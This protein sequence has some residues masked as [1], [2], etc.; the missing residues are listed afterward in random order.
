MSSGG[1]NRVSPLLSKPSPP[2]PSAG[3]VSKKG[4]STPRRSRTVFEYSR[5]LSRR[6]VTDPAKSPARQA[7]DRS[8]SSIQVAMRKR[9]SSDGCGPSGGMTRFRNCSATLVHK[10]R[11]SATSPAVDAFRNGAF[12]LGSSGLWQAV[13]YFASTGRMEVANSSDTADSAAHTCP[14]ETGKPAQ[15]KN[16][17]TGPIRRRHRFFATGIYAVC[18]VLKKP[19]SGE[20]RTAEPRSGERRTA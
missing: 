12:L 17:A 20:R 5:R 6:A 2:E 15:S 11:F 9:S 13:Q 18:I 10:P 8:S 16:R 1:R 7:V 3:K 4:R 14:V 19:R